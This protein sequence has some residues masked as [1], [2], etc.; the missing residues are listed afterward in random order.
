MAKSVTLSDIG[1]R[2][3][4]ST[5]TVSKALSGQPGVSDEMREKIIIL[6]DEM[7]YKR[8]AVKRVDASE[9]GSTI[10]VII[11]KQYMGKYD[12]FYLKMYQVINEK[13]LDNGSF[14]LLITIDGNDEKN[15]VIPKIILDGQVDGLI[16]AG[17]LSK[18]YIEEVIKQ[19]DLPRVF[20]DFSDKDGLEDAIISDSYYGAYQMTKYLIRNGHKK[21]AYVGTLLSTESITDRYMGYTRALMEAGITPLKE[22]QIDDRYLETGNV[23]EEKLMV[24]PEKM[25]TAFFCNCD[26]TAGM[27]I[28]KL[29]KEGYKVPEDISV[30]GY[31][32][33][34]YPGLSDIDITTYEVDYRKMAQLA[35]KNINKKLTNP[36]YHNRIHIVEG[37]LIEK[38]SV[39]SL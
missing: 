39:K 34:I 3:G 33:F 22:W 5:V 36:L 27:I 11:S 30:V 14:A 29:I 25:P 6:A 31:D 20:L 2:L 17:R 16:F 12:S 24:L 4:V 38:N 15:L 37:R 35:W 10:G 13:A 7:G 19:T 21:I 9:K 23:D 32:N 1:N 28:K 18:E 26:S 8:T